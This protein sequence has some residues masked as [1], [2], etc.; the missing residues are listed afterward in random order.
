MIICPTFTSSGAAETVGVAVAAGVDVREGD[1]T[2]ALAPSVA[3]PVGFASPPEFDE[4]APDS[5]TNIRP[6]NQ[7][8]FA[9]NIAPTVP[10]LLPRS[11]APLSA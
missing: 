3:C 8:T 6:P 10:P 5:A 4:H 2:V 1:A 9:R 11:R 7:T